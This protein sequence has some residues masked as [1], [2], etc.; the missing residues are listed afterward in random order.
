[1]SLKKIHEMNSHMMSWSYFNNKKVPIFGSFSLYFSSTKERGS[2]NLPIQKYLMRLWY[3]DCLL[4]FTCRKLV[5]VI[6]FLQ[7]SLISSIWLRLRR[8]GGFIFSRIF[9]LVSQNQNQNQDCKRFKT[10]KFPPFLDNPLDHIFDGFT[11]KH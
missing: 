5:N 2:L 7:P 6:L 8:I 11:F 9:S 4:L 10:F 1:M 3:V